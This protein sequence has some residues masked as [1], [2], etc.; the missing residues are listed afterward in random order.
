[1]LLSYSGLSTFQQCPNK[2]RLTYIKGLRS[3]STSLALE[4][5]SLCHSILED[6]LQNKQ[7]FIEKFKTEFA[8]LAT[9]YPE[10]I[11]KY[12]DK[13]NI[14]LNRLERKE[15][16]LEVIHV[17]K[18]FTLDFKT[19]QIR[20]FIDIVLRDKE[21]NYIVRDY[22]TNKDLYK[23]ADLENSLQLGIYALAVEQLF[24]VQPVRLEYDMVFHGR[25][26]IA[27]Y[28]K[29]AVIKKI[30]SILDAIDFSTE[31]DIWHREESVLCYWCPYYSDGL[32]FDFVC[33][34]ANKHL[35]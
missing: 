10:D 12:D 6:K 21:G 35:L 9:K 29:E 27:T 32:S 7:G 11:K 3:A 5:G 23:K 14:F 20:G 4:L 19:H 15:D 33:N 17:E 16:D 31:F 18:G 34:G 13:Y 8:K 24:G 1:M 30:N 25:T 28:D 26:Q 22:K 2:F